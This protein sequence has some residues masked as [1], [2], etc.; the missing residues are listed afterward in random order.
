MLYNERNSNE[1]EKLIS[2]LKACSRGVGIILEDPKKISHKCRRED[3]F[4]EELDYINNLLNYKII[5]IILNR[6]E[7]TFYKEIKNKIMTK[8]GIASQVVL[9]E[10]LSKNLS[11]FTN[12]LLQMN[13]KLGCELYHISDL[14]NFREKVNKNIILEYDSRIRLYSY[15]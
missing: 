1:A 15:S 5:V 4:L 14:P 10:N 11:Y 9:K 2:S 8:F 3:D 7:K 6:N 13:Y 12:V